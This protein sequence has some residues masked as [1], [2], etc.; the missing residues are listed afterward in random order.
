MRT[1]QN[2]KDMT[3]VV[4]LVK[5]N[6]STHFFPGRNLSM[7]SLTALNP[8]FDYLFLPV[9]DFKWIFIHKYWSPEALYTIAG[10]RQASSFI[11]AAI[12]RPFSHVRFTPG[13]PPPKPPVFTPD[14]AATT[15]CSLERISVKKALNLEL[16]QLRSICAPTQPER[17][18]ISEYCCLRPPPWGKRDTI[19]H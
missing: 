13:A 11:L 17:C 14:F 1:F 7:P 12:S 19:L 6:Q 8:N 2:F 18:T 10:Q 16:I 3:F 4:I 5:K 15:T 9:F